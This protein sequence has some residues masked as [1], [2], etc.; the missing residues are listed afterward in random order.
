MPV[1]LENIL[2]RLSVII[3]KYTRI[4]NSLFMY[5]IGKIWEISSIFR[6]IKNILDMN[7]DNC[8]YRS[9]KVNGLKSIQS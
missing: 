6:Y 2:N 8:H 7:T 4:L 5:F 3:R 9:N 1:N